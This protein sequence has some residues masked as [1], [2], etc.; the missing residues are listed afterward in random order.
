MRRRIWVALAFSLSGLAVMVEL[1]RG[2]ALDGLGVTYALIAAV[3][4]AAY[5][6]LAEREVAERDPVSLMA[7]GFLFATLLWTVV[8][9]WWSFPAHRVG[10]TV[11]LQ[12]HLA[13]W[14]LP[15]WAL[16]LWVVVLGSIV[17]FSLMVAGLSGWGGCPG[18]RSRR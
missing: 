13:S 15:V 16:V 6:L 17:P 4:F 5:L 10:R 7:W 14:H 3:I 18:P 1:W 2:I 8:Q 11:S 9:P 12:G